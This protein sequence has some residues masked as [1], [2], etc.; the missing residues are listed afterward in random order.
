MDG[1]RRAQDQRDKKPEG[2]SDDTKEAGQAWLM[3]LMGIVFQVQ[4]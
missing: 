2:Q 4:N 1:S 3:Y